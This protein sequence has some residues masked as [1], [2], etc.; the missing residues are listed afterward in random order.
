ML[1]WGVVVMIPYVLMVP[2]L[3]GFYAR[4]FQQMA[5]AEQ[6]GQSADAAMESMM[7]ESIALSGASNLLTI[8]QWFLAVIVATAVLRA[9]FTP[10]RDRWFNL[11]VGMD[12]LRY[13]VA[14]IALVIG[15]FVGVFI[16]ALVGAP[17][18]FLLFSTLGEPA[19]IFAIILLVLVLC[20][21]LWLAI[22]RVCFIPIASIYHRD[23]AFAEGWKRGKGQVGRLFGLSLL[24]FLIYMGLSLVAYIVAIVGALIALA[25]SGIEWGAVEPFAN[26]SVNWAIVGAVC[27]LLFLPLCFLVGAVSVICTA[28]YADAYRQLVANEPPS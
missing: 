15:V 22:L 2:L 4:M 16:L 23:F 25:G 26:V 19:G 8:L 1:I 7:A 21:V 6:T 9:V 13:A 14:V 20:V 10:G 5:V 12:E 3:G 28:P 18:G 24:I 27:A 11:R 17:L